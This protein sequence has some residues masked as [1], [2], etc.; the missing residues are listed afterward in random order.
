MAASPSASP[1]E[2]F[3]DTIDRISA[4]GDVLSQDIA[5]QD[6]TDQFIDLEARLNAL[7]TEEASLFTLLGIADSVTDIL[8]IER[9]LARIR[10]GIERLQ[11]QLNLLE[12]RVAMS[13]IT[14]S[15][16]GPESLLTESP[17]ASLTVSAGNVS[18]ELDATKGAHGPPGRRDRPR[19]H[20]HA[21]W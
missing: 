4:L 14:V 11:G 17:H 1:R 8:T 15:L 13:T 21:G 18:R 12:N 3:F 20:C 19:L 16:F 9:E 6:V 5:S 2:Q 7:K 10:A